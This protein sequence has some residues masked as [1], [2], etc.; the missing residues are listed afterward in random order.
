MCLLASALLWGIGQGEDK[1]ADQ[2][3]PVMK[4]N[5]Y[6]ITVYRPNE[7]DHAASL[8]ATAR[9]DIDKLNDEMAAAGVRVFVG[10]L[11]PAAEA[12][13]I[14]LCPD[15]TFAVADGGYLAAASYVDGFW[16]LTCEDLE[17]A[18]AWGRK[19]AAA[20]RASVEVRPFY[21]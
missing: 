14:Q 16:I 8:D 10:G 1:Y 12:K 2:V 21:G 3:D 6:W 18:M 11:R 15:G 13:S 9:Q 4:K 20:C 7:F 19:A 17:E 5:Q